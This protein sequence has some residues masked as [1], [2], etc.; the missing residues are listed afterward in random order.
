MQ[1]VFFFRADARPSSAGGASGTDGGRVARQHGA[2]VI[3]ELY[4]TSDCLPNP[5]E[6][7]VGEEGESPDQVPRLIYVD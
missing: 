4:I 1:N 5:S 6:E 2:G 7:A 3:S